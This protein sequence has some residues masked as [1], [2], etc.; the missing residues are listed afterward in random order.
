M[1]ARTCIRADGGWN[2]RRIDISSL[3]RLFVLLEFIRD[4]TFVHAR[5]SSLINVLVA[6]R[7]RLVKFILQELLSCA[8][9]L[10][11]GE[12]LRKLVLRSE[13]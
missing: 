6:L 2:S 1:S 9:R 12:I 5:E 7:S 4:H 3:L 10:L 13:N 8:E 11:M